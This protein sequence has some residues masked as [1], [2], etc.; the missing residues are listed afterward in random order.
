MQELQSARKQ[1][2]DKQG[3]LNVVIDAAN[4]LPK[5]KSNKVPRSRASLPANLGSA[6]KRHTNHHSHYAPGIH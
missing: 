3:K 4:N 5:M 6:K 1:A 2:Q